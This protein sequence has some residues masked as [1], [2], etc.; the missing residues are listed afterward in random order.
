M[1]K[2]LKASKYMINDFKTGL[3]IFYGILLAISALMIYFYFAYLDGPNNNASMGGFEASSII[4]IFISG[5]NCFKANFKFLQANNVS[6]RS[7]YQ[8]TII[9]LAA[10]AVFMSACDILLAQSLGRIIPYETMYNEIYKNTNI[11]SQFI[12]STALLAFFGA[13]GWFITMLYYKCNKVMKAVIS[14]LP[15]AVLLIAIK[16]NESTGG[17]V[18]RAIVKL[19]NF[20]FGFASYNS[21]AAA[22]SFLVLFAA[23]CGLCYLLV[24]KMTIKE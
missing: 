6:R 10:V 16:W 1:N 3:T 23:T 14:I 2:T 19:V 13:A 22:F 15:A 24:R 17:V 7:Y 20:A 8:A 21:Y 9:T 18:S 4:F 12:Y 5:L 11:F